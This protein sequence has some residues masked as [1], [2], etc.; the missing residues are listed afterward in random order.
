MSLDPTPTE[1]WPLAAVLV[2]DDEPGMRNFLEKTLAPRVA[3]VL[4]AETAED[5]DTL[6]RRHRFDLVILDIALPGKS[7]IQWLRELR[8]QGYAGEVVL[9]TAFADLDTAIEAL[10]AGASD[11]ILKPFRV[12]QLLNA[13]KQGLERALLKRENW[14][15]KRALKQRTPPPG[16]LVGRSAAIRSL[17]TAIELVAAVDSTVL[18]TGE[19]GT[20]KEL[21]ALALHRGSLRSGGPFVPVN[22]ATMS[23]EAIES[24]L[25]GH[26]ATGAQSA[27]DGL[28]VYAQGGTLFLDEIGELPMAMQ[29]SLLR[30]LED[31]R[32]RPVGSEQ[33]IPIDVR[34]VAASNRPLAAEVAA[35]RFRKDLY[36]R[37]QVV[38]IALP[39]LRTHKED[40][41]ELVDHFIDTLAPQLGVPPIAVGAD[42]LDYLR[43]YDWPGNVRELRNLIERSLILGA[44][45]VSA[46]YPGS[47]RTTLAGPTDLHALEKQHIL[48]VLDSVAGD[49]TQAARLLGISRR[50]L[51]RRV[52]EW[53]HTATT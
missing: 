36:Y 19:S 27:R 6:V 17:Q 24:E 3:H 12:T 52:A 1:R 30:V 26:A 2:V 15:L 39:A 11:F 35:G 51:E 25:F 37:L 42:E 9:I 31:R 7:G 40:I 13:V 45:N 14:V 28:F 34:I 53:S 10:R 29:A 47:T 22:C 32:V 23:P 41:A 50:T 44:L 46:L 21:A 16:A 5:A 49:K 20:G 48:A 38:E 4:A 8:E 18:L 43:Q 33:Q